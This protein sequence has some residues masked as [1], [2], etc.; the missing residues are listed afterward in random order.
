MTRGTAEDTFDYG[1]PEPQLKHFSGITKPL[2]VVFGGIDE[3]ADR[4][5]EQIK[6]VF[7][8]KTK[9]KHY[10]SVIISGGY[11]SFNGKEKELAG[12]IF[13]WVRVL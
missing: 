9:S 12:A 8:S 6:K 5:V 3:L 7:D 1:D 13:R 4:Q 10:R 11:H 2:L